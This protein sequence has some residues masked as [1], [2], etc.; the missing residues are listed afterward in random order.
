MK[1]AKVIGRMIAAGELEAN[2]IVTWGLL[3]HINDLAEGTA[4][5]AHRRAELEDRGVL[6]A[7]D[8]EPE[9]VASAKK[10][11]AERRAED[12]SAPKAKASDELAEIRAQLHELRGSSRVAAKRT[13]TRKRA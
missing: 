3:A 2:G 8:D 10:A 13:K 5:G 4:H 1:R 9:C 7:L 11:L 12:G 6:T